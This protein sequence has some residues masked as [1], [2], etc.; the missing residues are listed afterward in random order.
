[1]ASPQL[2]KAVVNLP[3]P[4]GQFN[5]L[6][7]SLRRKR[8]FSETIHAY[9]PSTFKR[10]D[11]RERSDEYEGNA[12]LNLPNYEVQLAPIRLIPGMKALSIII[13]DLMKLTCLLILVTTTE[14][15]GSEV[16]AR[17]AALFET[18][19]TAENEALLRSFHPSLS[20]CQSVHV[21]EEPGRPA[22]WLVSAN[23]PIQLLESHVGGRE[24][25]LFPPNIYPPTNE[26]PYTAELLAKRIN[27]RS[28]LSHADLKLIRSRFPGSVGMRVL[29][30]GFIVILFNDEKKMKSCWALGT[31][32]VIG[33][34]RVAYCIPS[35]TSIAVNTEG[36]GSAVAGNA[37]DYQSLSCLGL[38]LTLPN[39]HEVI[40]TTTHAF[41]KPSQSTT[42]RRAM[43]AWYLTIRSSL[44]LQRS[45]RRPSSTANVQARCSPTKSPLGKDVWL[46][47]RNNKVSRLGNRATEVVTLTAIRS[48]RLPLPT[49][50]F[51]SRE[52]PFHMVTDTT[53]PL[54]LLITYR[55]LPIQLTTQSS[56]AGLRMKRF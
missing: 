11:K 16:A 19:V 14:P 46:A 18:V 35:Y 8:P 34:Q 10:I 31:P 27:T 33:C 23:P 53:F 48:E 12:S 55:I 9:D 30:S 56:Q 38:R 52:C 6:L 15:W 21:L 50:R 2:Q 28:I 54:L 43:A 20:D 51:R 24:I 32:D 40:T 42:S 4:P 17:T 49:T 26:Y 29:I 1:M 47:G 3:T 37:N 25:H 39:G 36:Y 13:G 7:A 41:V 45:I 44:L 22:V 5:G